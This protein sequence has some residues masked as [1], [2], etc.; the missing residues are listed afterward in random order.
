MV[1]F[2]TFSRSPVHMREPAVLIRVFPDCWHW[3]RMQE[4]R[5]VHAK[6]N[7][8]NATKGRLS[9]MFSENPHDRNL[10]YL[11]QPSPTVDARWAI[12]VAG[13]RTTAGASGASHAQHGAL[14]L[15]P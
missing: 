9:T 2:R 6:E 5:I 1:G 8:V 13:C 11:A 10:S 7:G 3:V 14:S 15:A 4:C 12:L